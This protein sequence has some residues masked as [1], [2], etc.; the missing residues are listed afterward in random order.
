M[1]HRGRA[2]VVVAV[3]ALL[4]ATKLS[5]E[6]YRW[7]A[8]AEERT[9]IDVLR[10]ELGDAGVEIVRTQLA[11]DSLRERIESIDVELEVAR[12]QMA[13]LERHSVDGALPPDLYAVYE[14]Q[15]EGYNGRVGARNE[16][17]EEW[18]EIVARNHAA[19]RHYNE[20]ADSI[21]ALASAMGEPYYPLPTPAEIAV[22]RGAVQWPP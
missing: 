5:H 9:R 1:I 17:F 19:V 11:A 4:V 8:F 3:L 6:A 18:R 2:F 15:L 22:E 16:E 14:R 13:G 12:R 10:S 7:Y 20:L 21:R